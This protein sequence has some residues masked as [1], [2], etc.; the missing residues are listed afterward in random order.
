VRPSGRLCLIVRTRLLN[1]KDFSVKFLK[2]YVVQLSV[3]TAHVHHPD[4]ARIYH[5]SRPFEPSAYK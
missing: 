5:S 2:K 3:Q 1:M 4:G